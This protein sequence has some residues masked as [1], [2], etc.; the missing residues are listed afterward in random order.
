MGQWT[1]VENHKFKF[2]RENMCP[3]GMI[4]VT[5]SSEANGSREIGQ[6]LFNG[7]LIDE[8]RPLIVARLISSGVGAERT[9]CGVVIVILGVFIN[10]IFS[11][12]SE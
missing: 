6:T 2:S 4:C 10:L 11:A 3:Q 12:I 7:L 1:L 5:M 9:G 8:N